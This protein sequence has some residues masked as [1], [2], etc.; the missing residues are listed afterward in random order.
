MNADQIEILGTLRG[1]IKEVMTA[2]N[3]EREKNAKLESELQ[4][5]K[6]R[7]D[8]QEE[9]ITD[10]ERKYNNLKLAKVLTDGGEGVH[11]AKIKVN[12]IVREIDK[13]IALLNR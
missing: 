6:T 7:Y 3:K 12:S 1:R 5:F 9:R 10:L 11:D 4:S 2:L 8:Q 13:C